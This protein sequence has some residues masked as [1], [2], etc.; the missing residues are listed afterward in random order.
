MA[1]KYSTHS[2]GCHSLLDCDRGKFFFSGGKILAGLKE[3]KEDIEF[4][5]MRTASLKGG[6]EILWIEVLVFFFFKYFLC[7]RAKMIKKF[8]NS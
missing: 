3:A 2:K 5:G 4:L 6:V 1:I 8:L 7:K